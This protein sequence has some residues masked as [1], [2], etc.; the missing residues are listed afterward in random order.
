M[1]KL[2]ICAASAIFFATITANSQAAPFPSTLSIAFHR[3]P[4]PAGPALYEIRV[5]GLSFSDNAVGPTGQ[6]FKTLSPP[7]GNLSESQLFDQLIGNWKINARPFGPSNLPFEVY[8]F[9][10]SPFSASNLF[11]TPPIIVSPTA[12][13]TVSPNFLVNWV[14]PA[15]I[16]PPAG[17]IV[18]ATGGTPGANLD[19]GNFSD[20]SIPV[21]V[22]FSAG[23]TQVD[24]AFRAGSFEHLNN[25]ASAITTTVIDP[26]WQ[27]TVSLD[28]S[29]LSS[30]V[31]V[32]VSQVPE[33]GLMVFAGSLG[34]CSVVARRR[35]TRQTVLSV[36]A[37]G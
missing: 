18:V 28:Y 23:V 20:F 15:G 16:T 34:A 30:A 33:P 14:W 22:Q 8:E 6:V 3:L 1:N 37:A 26:R 10:I 27:F 4:Q 36:W 35:R 24:Y 11:T 12:G 17:K 9:S 25:R 31:G 19:F 2:L 32:T 21:S 29:N 13:S 5:S 7:L